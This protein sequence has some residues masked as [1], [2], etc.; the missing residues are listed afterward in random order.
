MNLSEEDIRLFQK[1]IEGPIRALVESKYPE[2]MKQYLRYRARVGPQC[3][4]C[5][6]AAKHIFIS[7]FSRNGSSFLDRF[8][9][10]DWST[11]E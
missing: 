8:K 3:A 7:E 5:K 11:Y 4:F 9:T 1:A 2:Y 10:E 6:A